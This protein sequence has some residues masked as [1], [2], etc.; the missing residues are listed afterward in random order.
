MPQ[1][2]WSDAMKTYVNEKSFN[3]PQMDASA[4]RYTRKDGAMR[5]KTERDYDI[6]TCTHSSL[7]KSQKLQQDSQRETAEHVT[8]AMDR[9]LK[10]AYH[11]YDIVTMDPKFGV[12]EATVAAVGGNQEPRGKRINPPDPLVNYDIICHERVP[13]REHVPDDTKPP[14]KPAKNKPTRST[15]V[16]NHQYLQDHD[17][18]VAADRQATQ[19]RIDR[20]VDNGR[21]FNPI[22]QQWNDA[23]QE[24]AERNRK[25]AAE[26]ERRD[27]VRTHTYKTSK[28]V[29]RSEG[30]AFDV[31]TN[32]VYNEDMVL[33]LDRRDATS[34]PQRAA[35]RQEWEQRRDAEEAVRDADVDR[36]LKR[37]AKDRVK[38]SVSHG[39][40]ILSN[41]P[42]VKVDEADTKTKPHL[43][44]LHETLREP[45]AMEKI[46]RA[47]KPK[48]AVAAPVLRQDGPRT[49]TE[50]LFGTADP[51]TTA[52][53]SSF[54]GRQKL[55][56]PTLD[57]VKARAPDTGSAFAATR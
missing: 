9:T 7:E 42:F 16:I 47:M 22:T 41:E 36:A 55:L 1:A 56:L 43:L 17:A 32:H 8:R 10:K 24:V 12:D 54:E 51:R 44:T 15:N 40:D 13:G 25:A 18:K 4:P 38:D 28:I 53:C 39:Y 33:A 14:K 20:A 34:I 27:V 2:T 50:R 21:A 30:H 31:V 6:V 26:Q 11:C 5:R 49:T 29:Q 57:K 45:S 35:L 19:Q 48:S 37:V 3:A 52:A 23:S 46:D